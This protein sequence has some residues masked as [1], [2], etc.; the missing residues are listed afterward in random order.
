VLLIEDIK[1]ILDLQ[2]IGLVE[3]R[4]LV[5]SSVEFGLDCLLLRLLVGPDHLPAIRIIMNDQSYW[6]VI[7]FNAE[8]Y[9]PYI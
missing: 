5:G 4:P 6:K 1:D 7:K 8:L 9:A 3:S 2:D